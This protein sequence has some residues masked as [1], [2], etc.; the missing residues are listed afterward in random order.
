MLPP[1]LARTKGKTVS[2]S[3]E[4]SEDEKLNVGLM[5]ELTSG[6]DK[7][8]HVVFKEPIEFKLNSKK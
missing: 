2:T 3:Q 5:K 7:F 4:P 8:K 6:G 1:E